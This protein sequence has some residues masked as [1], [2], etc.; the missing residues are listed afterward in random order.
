M[1]SL[2]GKPSRW[3]SFSLL[4]DE[5]VLPFTVGSMRPSIPFATSDIC[6]WSGIDELRSAC[7]GLTL[8]DI[9][10]ISSLGEN[11]LTPR[12]E[13]KA[14]RLGSRRRKD[15]TAARIALKRLARR[16]GL[17][18]EEKPDREIETLG[19][20]NVRPC[21]DQT[22][23]YCSV[24]HS[25]RLVV[26]VAHRHP[27][28]VDL[29]LVSEKATR[30]WSRFLSPVE[31]DIAMQSGLSQERAAARAWTSKEAAAKA[32]GLHLF[33][34]IHEVNVVRLREVEGVIRYQTKDYPVRHAE[35][36]GYVVSLVTCDDIG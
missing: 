7:L 31:S 16:L 5:E 13:E 21:L 11:L 35:G 23:V 25:G 2:D 1:I 33:Q 30:V 18:I 4:R 34:A 9:E 3:L 24:S 8:L 20:D 26:A 12:E 17:V 15:F 10:T 6:D 32:F 28:G 36:N 22:G 29:E 27:I 19:P 14:T